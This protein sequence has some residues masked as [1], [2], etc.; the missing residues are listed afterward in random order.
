MDNERQELVQKIKDTKNLVNEFEGLQVQWQSLHSKFIP[1]PHLP[2][3]LIVIMFLILWFTIPIAICIWI[4]NAVMTPRKIAK[5]KPQIDQLEKRA[6]EVLKD[7]NENSIVPPKY[8]YSWA[9]N[10]IEGYLLNMRADSLKECLNLLEQEIQYN[11][12]IA[13]FQRIQAQNEA[14]Y[15]QGQDNQF[16]GFMNLVK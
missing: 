10:Q 16:I 9:L 5:N 14:L 12:Q 4:F 13:H 3:V 11:Q 8:R 6:S 2:V 7:L 1:V 15:R